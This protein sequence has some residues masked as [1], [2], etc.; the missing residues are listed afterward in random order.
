MRRRPS[1]QSTAHDPTTACIFVVSIATLSM[2]C[3]V[4]PNDG[5]SPVIRPSS[6]H[7]SSMLTTSFPAQLT[8]VAG[9]AATS[10]SFGTVA[11]MSSSWIGLYSLGPST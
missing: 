5:V 6:A 11:M 7:Q 4:G 8:I 9:T 3:S 1:R 2:V 10:S